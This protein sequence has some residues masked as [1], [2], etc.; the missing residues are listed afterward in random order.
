MATDQGKTSNV[1]GLALMA[2]LT[3]QDHPADRHDHLPPALYA[4]RDR[5]ARRHASRQGL[6]AD[7]AA[8]VAPLGAGAGRGVRRDRR[9]GCARSGIRGPARPIGSRASTARCAPVRASVGVCDVSTLG[10]IDLQGARRG[11]LPGPPLHQQLEDPG[12]RQGALRPHAARG[13]IGAGRRHHLA[14]RRGPLHH[15]HH[16]RQ[17]RQGPAAHGVLPPVAVAGARRAVLLGERAVGA[18]LLRRPALARCPA[19]D[20]RPPA[21]HLQCG[22]SL[23]GGGR[24]DRHGRPAGATVPHLLLGRAG[25]RD[26]RARGLWRRPDARASW[27]PAASSALRP[28]AR[29]RSA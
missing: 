10:K 3:A 12:R 18:V 25:L 8:A 11:R 24:T 13:R 17:R 19:Q 20:R 28:T 14:P 4:G 2:E 16:H 7:A 21:R 15:H 23:H 26:R 27:R 5:R 1:N 29:R 6:Q 9:Y 22:L